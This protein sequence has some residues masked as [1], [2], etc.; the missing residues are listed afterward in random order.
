MRKTF[1]N[2]RGE[3]GVSLIGVLTFVAISAVITLAIM[4]VLNNSWHNLAQQDSKVGQLSLV[5]DIRTELREAGFCKK[6][7]AQTTSRYALNKDGRV[8]MTMKMLNNGP[9]IAAGQEAAGYNVAVERFEF[10]PEGTFVDL[11]G[12]RRAY[13]G[14]LELQVKGTKGGKNSLA[15]VK[16]G[17]LFLVVNNSNT[18]LEDCLTETGM[19]TSG[20]CGPPPGSNNY[21]DGINPG[22]LDF[23]N[24]VACHDANGQS[25]AVY[26]EKDRG[27][28][29][30]INQPLEHLDRTYPPGTRC[31]GDKQTVRAGWV[32]AAGDYGATITMVCENVC[33]GSQWI[34]SNC[35]LI[36]GTEKLPV[37]R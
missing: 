9:T 2:L 30:I 33:L 25:L 28:A 3:D 4:G 18:A 35:N 29:G 37:V 17:K 23:N 34:K 32:S 10:I 36:S 14:E 5:Q 16:A 27:P 21:H 11:P 20:S 31:T 8:N 1:P 13:Y 6:T 26:K 24:R 12:N 19:S 7:L 15:P 22:G